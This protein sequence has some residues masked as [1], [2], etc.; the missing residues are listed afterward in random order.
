[1]N[2]FRIFAMGYLMAAGTEEILQKYI[3]PYFGDHYDQAL[4]LIADPA[5]FRVPADYWQEARAAIKGMAAAGVDITSLSATDWVLANSFLDV[6]GVISGTAKSDTTTGCSSLISWGT[7]T[8]GTD[9]A[10]ESVLTRHLDW[11]AYDG[12]IGNDVVVVHVPSEPDEQ[13]WAMVAYTGFNSAL[14][15]MNNSGVGS[16]AHI[17]IDRTHGSA[18][19]GQGYIPFWY[20][21]RTGLEKRDFNQD[22]SNDVLDIQA[23]VAEST[24]GFGDG[25]I[26]SAVALAE[27]KTA[28][29]IALVGEVSPG[30]PYFSF[31]DNSYSDKIPG[32]NLMTANHEIGRSDHR[33]YCGRYDSV[34]LEIGDGTDIGS[35]ES[36]ALMKSHSN[37]SALGWDN[38]QFMQFIPS[39]GLLKLSVYDPAPMQAYN[40]ELLVIDLGRLFVGE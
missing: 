20:S 17:M 23:A 8:A 7:A 11:G 22:G 36:L 26:F 21:L 25:F 9:L 34:V 10:G 37:C 39:Q 2:F 4:E 16:F 14:S 24:H 29:R 3:I 5:S 33:N 12:I 15:G 30:A 6:K 31:R 13:P 38:L 18:S 27:G 40:R 32:D 1:M 28:N 35:A 19:E